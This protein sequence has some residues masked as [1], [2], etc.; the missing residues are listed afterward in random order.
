M[1]TYLLH[2]KQTKGWQKRSPQQIGKTSSSGTGKRKQ[3][4]LK[5]F[6]WEGADAI[7]NT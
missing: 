6:I 5:V 7:E 2:L 3:G 4:N 1:E